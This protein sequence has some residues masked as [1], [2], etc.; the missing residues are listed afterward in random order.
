[1]ALDANDIIFDPFTRKLYASVPSTASQVV[2][3][4]IVSIDPGT[5]KLGAPVFIGSEPTRL[6]ISDDGTYLYAVL[7]GANAVRRMNL[8]TLAPGTQF[9]TVSPL[10]GPYAASDVAVMPGNP[11]A[12]AT[13]GYTDGIKVRTSPIAEQPLG[14]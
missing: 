5:G 7:S 8:T 1:M 3:N 13:C 12:I 9:T 14:R 4:S 11:N 6:G 2:G 10:F